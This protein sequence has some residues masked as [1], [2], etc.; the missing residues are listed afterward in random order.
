MNLNGKHYKVNDKEN[1]LKRLCKGITSIEA[2]II[3]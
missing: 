3:S 2:N 1:K